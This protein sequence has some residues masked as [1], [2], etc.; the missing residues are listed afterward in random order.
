[1]V[2]ELDRRFPGLGRQVEESMAVPIGGEDL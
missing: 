1:M 2:L